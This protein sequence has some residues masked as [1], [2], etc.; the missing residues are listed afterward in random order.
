MA[1]EQL[2]TAATYVRN[3]DC[4]RTAYKSVRSSLLSPTIY[5]NGSPLINLC[6]I[7]AMLLSTGQPKTGLM[8]LRTVTERHGGRI[9]FIDD[10][11]VHMQVIDTAG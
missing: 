2:L 9:H 10:A 3:I 6:P 1:C 8:S 4:S 5:Y 7:S 11:D